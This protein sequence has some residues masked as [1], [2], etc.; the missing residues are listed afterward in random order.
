EGSK[1]LTVSESAA[2]LDGQT[3]GDDWSARVAAD[4]NLG[5]E[6]VPV[7]AAK[8]WG[9]DALLKRI[10]DTLSATWTPVNVLIPYSESEL[11]SL[12]HEKGIIEQEEHTGAGTKIAGRIPRRYTNTYREYSI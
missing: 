7:S 3:A 5:P 4:L 12:F 11:V 1:R 2:Q 10:Q 9:L 6:Y 8:S